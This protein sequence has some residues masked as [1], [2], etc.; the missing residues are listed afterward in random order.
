MLLHE[1]SRYHRA[2][3]GRS[4][5][6]YQRAGLVPPEE[7]DAEER[8]ATCASC[9]TYWYPRIRPGG[10]RYRGW[11]KCPNGCNSD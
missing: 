11:W 7:H 5:A 9:G 10:R 8:R 2:P 3:R 1:S 6:E 4:A